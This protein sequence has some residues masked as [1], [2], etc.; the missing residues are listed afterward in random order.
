MKTTCDFCKQDFR[1]LICKRE[2]TFEKE[3]V[4]ENFIKCPNCKK[5]YECY[6]ENQYIS[7]NITKIKRLRQRKLYAITKVSKSFF[8]LQIKFYVQKNKKE[9]DRIK[10]GLNNKK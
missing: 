2:H 6:Y 7:N 10:L 1:M 9:S 8:D 3:K 5:K 4:I